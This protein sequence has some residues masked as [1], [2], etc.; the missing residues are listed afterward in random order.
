M[1]IHSPN[2]IGI[3]GYGVLGR[4]TER[5]FSELYDCPSVVVDPAIAFSDQGKRL[6]HCDIVFICV[7]TPAL[8]YGLDT[9]AVWQSLKLLFDHPNPA[10]RLVVIRSTT[11]CWFTSK[12]DEICYLPE[13]LDEAQL[14]DQV[15]WQVTPVV[16]YLEGYYLDDYYHELPLFQDVHKV[17][18]QEAITIKLATN[19]FYA[20]K[21][22]FFEQLYDRVHNAESYKRIASVLAENPRIGNSHTEIG[23][24]G[25]RGFGGKCLPKDV[26]AWI[27]GEDTN[28]R[29]DPSLVGYAS[30]INQRYVAAR[31]AKFESISAVSSEECGSDLPVDGR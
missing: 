21:L 29:L 7:P 12:I 1:S 17:S 24:D 6:A 22:I 23:K 30:I 14:K 16:G 26:Q 13:F 15:R 8:E 3:I 18:F 31:S 5:Y 27:D 4:W 2:L 28:P 25:Y 11:D 19:A 20:T 10:G 9:S